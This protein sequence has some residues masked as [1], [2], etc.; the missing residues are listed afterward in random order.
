[1]ARAPAREEA[2]PDDFD[3]IDGLASPA[4]QIHLVGQSAAERTLLDAYRSGRLHH[5]WILGGPRGV[6]KAT[7]AFRFARFLLANPDPNAPTVA[8]ARDLSVPAGHPAGRLVASGAHP[9]LLHL[10]RPW[11]DKG[12]RFRSELTVDEVRRL[13]PFFGSTASGG[14]WRVAI[15]DP[16]D[17][18]NTNAANALLKMLEE[19][20]ARGLFLIVSHAPGRLLPTIRSRARRLALAPLGEADLL[21]AL[22]AIGVTAERTRLLRAA[23]AGE[24]SVRRAA[25]LATGG[26]VEIEDLVKPVIASLGR[27]LDRRALHALAD[28]LAQR[29]AEDAFDHALGLV[30]SYISDKVRAGSAAGEPLAKLAAWPEVWEKIDRAVGRAEA[31]NLDRRQL[32]LGIFRDLAEAERR[33][34]A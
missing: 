15:V 22:Q 33:A 23:A 4:A 12:K 25:Q 34:R 13:T 28:A 31:F 29:D 16:A 11:D 19:P 3:A 21:A 1:M 32:V 7:L 30:Q 20:P 18:L 9:D 10:R 24:G 14:G 2:F 17:D 5:G 8:A 6:G 26:A 27:D